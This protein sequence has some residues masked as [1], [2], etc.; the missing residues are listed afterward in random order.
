MATTS[1]VLVTLSNFQ[2]MLEYP[3][4]PKGLDNIQAREFLLE[5][6]VF[7]VPGP[8]VPAVPPSPPLPG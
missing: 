8:T 5:A 2:V 4:D 1:L 7:V 6:E 3:F